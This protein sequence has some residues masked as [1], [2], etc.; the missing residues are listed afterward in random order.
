MEASAATLDRGARPRARPRAWRPAS[1]ARPDAR[2]HPVPLPIILLYSPATAATASD[3]KAA[4]ASAQA[5]PRMG[6]RELGVGEGRGGRS[7]RAARSGATAG[8]AP[9]GEGRAGSGGEP[10]ICPAHTG[11]N[12]IHLLVLRR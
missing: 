10:A 8:R 7:R 6:G 2:R 1:V 5:R 4:R 11:P 3:A 12:A 9:R